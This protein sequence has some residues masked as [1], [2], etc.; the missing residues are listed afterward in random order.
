MRQSLAAMLCFGLAAAG[1]ASA[2]EEPVKIGLLLDMS[3][4]YADVTGIGSET[5]ARM[6]VQDFGG[7]VLGRPIEVLAADHLN[8]PDIASAKAREWFDSDHV[9]AI[10]DVA[11][12]APALAVM[13]V[14]KERNKLVVLS[15]P[16]SSSITGEACIPTALHWAY[17][18]Y[19]LAHATGE[20]VL[21]QGGD[22]W[23]F[24]TADYSFGYQLEKD[25]SD[26]VTAGG[27]KVLGDVKVPLATA[28]FSSFLLQ[29][30]G[31]KAKIIGLA[32]AGHDFTNSVK[33]A[34]EFGLVAGG[35][36]LAG[37]LVYINDIHA[38]GLEA[39][40]GMMFSS[41]FYWDRTDESRAWSKRFF[42]RL[43]RMPNMSQA[44]VY[45][46]TLH[47]LKAVAKAGT[48]DTDAVLK[49]MKDM[50]VDDLFAKHG[51][52]REDGLM[53]HD[54]YLFQ[55]KSPAESKGP[56]DYYKLVATVPGSEAFAPMSESKCPLVKK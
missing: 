5:A 56:W 36:K 7:T 27:G 22:S 14:A 9:A 48:T 23:F 8:K 19:A 26:V 12:T 18:T 13:G 17:D 51:H 16:G 39:T 43:Q 10:L 3:G 24:I 6:A 2:A 28:D 54:M 29:A 42:E 15:G 25:T 49:A 45:S 40:Q 21:K 4:V 38:L 1:T 50:P 35:Q 20:A 55:V 32:N 31:S 41:A 11:A 46:S 53:E 44:G 34:A 52:I 47:Y 30:Q 37:L 33:Q